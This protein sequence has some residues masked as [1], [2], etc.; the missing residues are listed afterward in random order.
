MRKSF[1][2]ALAAV[3]VMA[4]PTSLSAEIP[5]TSQGD[6]EQLELL[7]SRWLQSYETRDREAL[8]S[9]LGDEFI[10]LY[11]PRV[12]SKTQ[13]LAGLDTSSIAKVR[14]DDLQINVQGDNAV[15]T[16]ISTIES[17]QGSNSSTA[18][19]RY[20]DIY[21]RRGG[22]WQAVASHVVRFDQPAK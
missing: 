11:G 6:R 5:A 18:R 9:V 10:G 12:L 19:Y 13:M 17:M 3:L 8:G 7:N 15:V 2:S 14:W 4:L 1:V 16:A 22:Q 21:S 20:V